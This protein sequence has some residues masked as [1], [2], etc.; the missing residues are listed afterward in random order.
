M[1]LVAV[2]LVLGCSSGSDGGSG[3]PWMLG[4]GGATEEPLV[5]GGSMGEGGA[6][7][8]TTSAGGALGVGGSAPGVGGASLA[9]GGAVSVGGYGGGGVVTYGGSAGT[10][11]ASTDCRFSDPD[12]SDW[13]SETDGNGTC[14]SGSCEACPTNYLDCD[15]DPEN[16]CE[17]WRDE[18]QCE[19]CGM[20]CQPWW[21]CEI[22]H[23]VS[24]NF[25]YCASPS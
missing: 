20:E 13:C 8:V 16:G 3:V 9:S 22:G 7:T 5:V 25:K 1:V 12:R 24:G 19:G 4:D 15:G 14:Q 10:G 17:V 21:T 18:T 11:G 23:S 2:A 6:E